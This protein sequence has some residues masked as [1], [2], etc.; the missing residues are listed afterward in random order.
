MSDLGHDASSSSSEGCLINIDLPGARQPNRP[1]RQA[2]HESFTWDDDAIKSCL[3]VSLESYGSVDMKSW[4]IASEK[5]NSSQEDA[6]E[7]SLDKWEPPKLKLPIWAINPLES[8]SGPS[9]PH[10]YVDESKTQKSDDDPS[11]G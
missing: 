3:E 6:N 2:P 1:K 9:S 5:V 7:A 11:I 10:S 4:V 8:T